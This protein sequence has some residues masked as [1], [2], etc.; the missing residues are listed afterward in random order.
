MRN[1]HY[2]PSPRILDMRPLGPYSERAYNRAS[3][4]LVR[5]AQTIVMRSSL[6]SIIAAIPTLPNRKAAISRGESRG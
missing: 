1:V 5:D 3:T 6:V 4:T 2:Q